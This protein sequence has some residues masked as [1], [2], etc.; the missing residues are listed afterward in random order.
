MACDKNMS[1]LD[2]ATAVPGAS[3]PWPQ[4]IAVIC[5]DYNV[6]GVPPPG[7]WTTVMEAMALPKRGLSGS[8]YL[9][10]GFEPVYPLSKGIAPVGLAVFGVVPGMIHAPSDGWHRMYLDKY[11]LPFDIVKLE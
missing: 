5:G 1:S 9:T 10:D 7:A 3:D 4:V 11:S 2:I 6:G 8:P